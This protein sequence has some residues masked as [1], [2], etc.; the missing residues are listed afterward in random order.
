[1]GMET[2][3]VSKK[4]RVL[5]LLKYQVTKFV[6]DVLGRSIQ[7]DVMDSAKDTTIFDFIKVLKPEVELPKIWTDGQTYHYIENIQSFNKLCEEHFGIPK[8]DLLDVRQAGNSAASTKIQMLNIL[9]RLI[10][11]AQKRQLTDKQLVDKSQ[12]PQ[13]SQGELLE[14]SKLLNEAEAEKGKKLYLQGDVKEA[15]QDETETITVSSEEA[16][17]ARG[18][19]SS[20]DPQPAPADASAQAGDSSETGENK[21]DNKLLKYILAGVAGL[22]VLKTIF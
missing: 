9:Y 1:M 2:M 20:A 21:Q 11:E 10:G 12:A 15:Q 5:C 8:D 14:A 6:E 22:A 4:A 18:E 16:V 13:F 19:E 17:R 7:C 3:I